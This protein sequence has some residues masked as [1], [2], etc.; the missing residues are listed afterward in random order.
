MRLPEEHLVGQMDAQAQTTAC[1]DCEAFAVRSL[2]EIAVRILS[3]LP[4]I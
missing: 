2:C 3:F 4:E 1:S